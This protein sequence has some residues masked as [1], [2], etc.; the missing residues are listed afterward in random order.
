VRRRHGGA[1]LAAADAHAPPADAC[2][3]A[4]VVHGT[5]P[6]HRRDMRVKTL[7]AAS[8]LALATSAS[9]QVMS[10]LSSPQGSAADLLSRASRMAA[11]TQRRFAKPPAHAA[12]WEHGTRPVSTR[13][14]AW[15]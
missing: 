6:A 12:G 8:L 1:A 7:V 3:D 5:P 10:S 2:A 11:E 14:S 13:P 9:A 4:G 15:R